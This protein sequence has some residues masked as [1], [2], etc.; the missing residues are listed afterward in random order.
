[1][2]LFAI[3]FNCDMLCVTWYMG[4]GNILKS[5]MY[6]ASCGVNAMVKCDKIQFQVLT[7]KINKIGGD[8]VTWG[9]LK[10]RFPGSKSH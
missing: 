10:P 6:T 1:M 2:V 5:E 4:R 3:Y 7:L 9:R 8:R